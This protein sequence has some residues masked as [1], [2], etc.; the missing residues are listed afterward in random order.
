MPQGEAGNHIV[1]MLEIQ[2]GRVLEGAVQVSGSKNGALPILFASILAE[3]PVT[4]R[5]VPGLS[6]IHHTLEILSE[7]GLSVD[8]QSEFFGGDMTITIRAGEGIETTAPYEMVRQM[9]ASICCL[10]PLL[11]RKGRARVSLPGGCAIGDRPVDLHLKGLRALGAEIRIEHGYIE[12]R[13]DRLVG[14]R[15]YLSGAFGPTVLGTQNVM[16]AAARAE[17]ETIIE[18]AACEPEV[19][20]LARFLQALGVSVEGAGTHQIRIVGQPELGGTDFTVPPDRIEAGTYILTG[21]MAGGTVTVEGCDPGDLS[22]LFDVLERLQVPHEVGSDSVTVT[23][24]PRLHPIDIATL[25][26]PG[27]PTDFQAQLMALLTRI[28]GISI[29]TEK[30]YPDRFMHVAELNRLG[31]RIRKEGPT[32]II[33]GG[34]R[35]SGADVMA[36]DLRA[37]ASL[38]MAGLVAEGTTRVHRIYHLDRGY[39]RMEKKLRNLGAE[40]ARKSEQSAS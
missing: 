23:G 4:I 40:I 9:R 20:C 7:L 6:D 18:G 39:V 3:A 32:A 34:H 24:V 19:V 10:G 1:E 12:A 8:T 27:F 14:A 30:V 16:M 21:A 15:M 25:P 33:E 17:G 28:P 29:L 35:L 38:V 26:H 22:S 11:A 37:S 31:A 13:A 5:N 36:S 2:G